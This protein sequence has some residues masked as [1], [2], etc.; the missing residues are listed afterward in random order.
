MNKGAPYSIY[1]ER[2]SLKPLVRRHRTSVFSSLPH[3]LSFLCTAHSR[4]PQANTP[5]SSMHL[6]LRQHALHILQ[7]LKLIAFT[8]PFHPAP[9]QQL[10]FSSLLLFLFSPLSLDNQKAGQQRL[11]SR[12]RL[13][14]VSPLLTRH[15]FFTTSS[16]RCIPSSI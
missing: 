7:K 11:L 15:T 12:K 13:T 3:S 9:A 16:C 4:Q 10:R 14:G 2:K 8:L 5:Q 1:S 6:V